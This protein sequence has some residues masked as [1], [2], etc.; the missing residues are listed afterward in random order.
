MCSNDDSRFTLTYCTAMSNWVRYAFV[1]GRGK[2]WIFSETIVVY[3]IKIGP[4]V[5]L[6]LFTA[7]SNL[8][9]FVSAWG[10]FKL[11]FH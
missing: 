5:D 6:D 11:L 7:R 2:Q 10:V 3:D 8:V 4:W 9:P 1:R